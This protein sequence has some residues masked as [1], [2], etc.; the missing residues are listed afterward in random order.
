[1]SQLVLSLFP[2]I[3]LL[4][5]AFEEEGFVVVRGPD[6][7]WGGDI[8]NFHPPAGKFDGVIGGPPCQC[9]SGLANL[10]RACGNEPH[11]G[12]LIPEFERCV[13][14]ARPSWFLME[15]V[16]QAPAPAVAGYG[17]RQFILNNCWLP[18]EDPGYGQEQSR[19]RMFS[20]GLRGR[21]A[22]LLL[23]WIE[24]ATFELPRTCGTAVS[25][26]PVN[27]TQE[28]KGRV[29]VGTC[30]AG[31]SAAPGQR[32]P[33]GAKHRGVKRTAVTAHEGATCL[34]AT[35]TAAH[36]GEK[37]PKGGALVRYRFEEAC[38][39]QGLPD[40]FLADAPFTAQGK[41]KAVANGVPIP[42]GRALAKAVR[43]AIGEETV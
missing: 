21:K 27:N 39:L 17:I 3:G 34:R 8:R 1:M 20:F 30:I 33:A 43:K 38:R 31:G 19:R 32:D 35:V 15:E 2:G 42:M 18:G 36:S 12:N 13:A 24:Q 41:L 23:K 22:P 40:D 11:F 5:R 7:L 37:R 16:P 10:V 25:Q 14:E 9:F 26:N 28:A 29:L 4:D 6:V